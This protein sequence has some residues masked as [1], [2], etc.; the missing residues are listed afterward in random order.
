MTYAEL[1][2]NAAP[3]A[4]PET[5]SAILD[6]TICL[7]VEFAKWGIVRKASTATIE[8]NA[9]KDRL[10]LGVAL[11][12]LP[13]YDAVVRLDREVVD[14][15]SKIA[16][17]SMLKRSAHLIP[18]ESVEEVEGALR[19]F[20]ARRPVLVE[21]L[22]AKLPE[23]KADARAKLGSL[24]DESKYPTEDAVRDKF[25]FGWSYVDF[26]VPGKLKSISSK[27][28]N[29]EAEKAKGRILEAETKIHAWLTEGYGKLVD[30]M[31]E[32]LTPDADGKKKIFR[33]TL[34]T[35][36]M[37]FLGTID[38]RA[39][40]VGAEGLSDLTAK[41][42]RLLDGVDAA[43]LRS[44]EGLRENTRRGFA[45]IAAGLDSLVVKANRGTRRIVLPPSDEAVA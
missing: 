37:E 13:E 19:A 39:A 8:T 36:L 26:G 38:V 12:D 42:K 21:A 41:A 3:A 2:T 34:V 6:K 32:R 4:V 45:E 7:S 5:G 27:I 44:N 22:L 31:V 40:A 15:L 17:P 16:M 9:D 24:F 25:S 11:I 14:Y 23:A 43:D 35:N 28:F 30:A 20:A 33:D 29:S 10:R 1:E 18:L